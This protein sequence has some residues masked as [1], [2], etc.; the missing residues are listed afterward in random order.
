MKKWKEVPLYFKIFIMM[1]LGAAVGA[2]V[3]EKIM[4]VAFFGDI[5]I[6]LLKML[7]VPLVFF[8]I[9]CGVTK[10]ADPKEFGRIGGSVILYYLIT[11]VIAAAFGVFM[12]LVIS[13]GHQAEG[14]LGMAEEV[15]YTEYSLSA[16][17]LSWIPSNIVKSMANMDMIP[18]IV[19]AV[20]FGL[21]LVM[22]GDK[23]KPMVEFFEAGN[24]AMLKMTGLVAEISP[25]GIFFLTAKLVGT[26]GSKMLVVGLKFAVADY[27]GLLG[28]LLIGYPVL[29]KFIAKVSPI[30]FYKNVY[31]AMIVAAG[32]CSSNATLPVSMRCAEER[33]GCEEKLYSFAL[34]LGATVNMD[35][36]SVA[37]GIISI[38]ALQ[39]YGVPLTPQIVFKA[40]FMGLMLSVGA[41]GVKGTAVVMSAVLFQALGLPMGMLPLIG[42]IWP[43]VDIG[44]TTTN[45]TSDLVGTTIVGCKQ[46]LIDKAV[47]NAA[48]RK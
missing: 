2:V 45:I 43:L 4:A 21:C 5:Y 22:I 30:Q 38:T 16:T 41:P 24:E 3:G 13:P 6:E 39:I 46:N 9:I 10:L 48:N 18:V 23:K 1:I 17:L 36:F 29:L 28:L 40:V 7:V 8:S 35:G 37:L 33:L 19:F 14:I 20:L 42:A 12:A 47:F 15:A 26:I 44:H 11:T 34:P 27:L 31:P 25:Y 32:T